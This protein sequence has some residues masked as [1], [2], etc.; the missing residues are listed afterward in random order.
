MNR[1][2][3]PVQEPSPAPPT[4]VVESELR[5]ARDQVVAH[6]AQLA[7]AGSLDAGNG[8]VM[9]AWLEGLRRE[10]HARRASERTNSAAA[11]QGRV[12]ELE[13]EV[14]KT[15][16]LSDAATAAVEDAERELTAAKRRVLEPAEN[17]AIDQRERRRRPRATSDPLEGLVRPRFH[18]FLV[19]AFL[20][21]AALGDVAT[22]RLV[23]ATT[24][25]DGEEYVVW[26]LTLAFAAASV[27]LMHFVG[28][29]WKELRQARGGLG[30]PS[31]FLMLGG[32]LLLGA[33]AFVFRVQSQ[34]S[35]SAA[36]DVFGSAGAAQA[37]HDPLL[38]ALLLAGL[39]VA[40]GLLAFYSGFTEHHP[41]MTT[42]L[43]LRETLPAHR[44]AA[45]EAAA[46]ATARQQE[47]A[48]ARTEEA[49]AHQ[50]AADASTEIDAGIDALKEFVRV[51]V[52]R[53]IGLPEATSGLTAGR[54][55]DVSSEPTA[56]RHGVNLV[57]TSRDAH[58][59]FHGNG[60]HAG[61]H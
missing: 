27:G 57:P 37:Q 36:S 42:Y 28:R 43:A 53:Y 59:R 47:L 34:D 44:R 51:E 40:S 58:D 26:M 52:A 49:R 46:V 2:S 35:T 45:A 24:F 31:I 21:V 18:R 48:L 6:V 13:A 14:L 1:S 55:A 17:H 20:V 54:G 32:W 11:A 22:F 12:A 19:I 30:R 23:I 8:D 41:H 16:K 29:A 5:G 61:S 15:R 60:T 50:R 56:R 7:Q 4:S 25:T 10:M 3:L 33:V 38:S 9:D 39:Y